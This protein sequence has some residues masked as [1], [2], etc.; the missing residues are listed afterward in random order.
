MPTS[1]AHPFALDGRT[2]LIVGGASGIGAATA[3][4]CA[5]LGGSLVLADVADATPLAFAGPR[6]TI[7]NEYCSFRE[8]DE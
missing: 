4:T 3:T 8:S 1:A 2:I 5:A 7:L 6:L